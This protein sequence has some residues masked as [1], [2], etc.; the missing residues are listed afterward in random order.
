MCIFV[1]IYLGIKISMSIYFCVFDT[2][3]KVNLSLS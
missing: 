1:Y 3:F 2:I